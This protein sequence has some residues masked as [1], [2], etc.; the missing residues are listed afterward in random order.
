MNKI[1]FSNQVPVYIVSFAQTL[2]SIVNKNQIFDDSMYATELEYYLVY[3]FKMNR[4][5]HYPLTPFSFAE[6]VLSTIVVCGV[7]FL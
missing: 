4:W 6:I 7:E 3:A 5:S 2:I 1:T